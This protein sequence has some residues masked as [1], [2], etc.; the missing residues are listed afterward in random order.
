MGEETAKAMPTGGGFYHVCPPRPGCPHC[1]GGS[2][3]AAEALDWSFLDAAYC[4]SLKSRED[5]A[6]SA[7][8]EFHRVGLC[9]RVRFFRPERHPTKPI[10]GIWQSHR[11]VALEALRRGQRT[12]AI[13]E[14]DVQFSRRTSPARVR[15]IRT[16]LESLP[17]DWTILFLG[18]WPLRAWFVAP[19][20]L[21][22]ASACCHAYI[23]SPRLLA[24]LQEHPPERP[25]TALVRLAGAGIDAAYAALPGTF[26]YFPMVAV[27]GPFKSDH[28]LPPTRPKRWRLKHLF[29]RSRYR[30]RL[31][32]GLMR[33]N[34]MVIAA[35]SPLFWLHHRLRRGRAC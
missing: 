33:P 34:E 10:R 30:E 29:S 5:R 27:Q 8:A 28:R 1:S 15:S 26:A 32:S 23:A 11:E 17:C 3:E 18:H 13:F 31:L 12:I 25:D 35:L 4:I 20:L 7:A 21:R 2:A 19:H 16:A 14:D 24:W 22:T 6:A 9:G